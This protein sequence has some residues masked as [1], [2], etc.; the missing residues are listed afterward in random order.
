MKKM[1]LTLNK[2]SLRPHLISLIDN[3]QDPK[4]LQDNN[5]IAMRRKR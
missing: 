1:T 4:K 3:I 5:K 2:V